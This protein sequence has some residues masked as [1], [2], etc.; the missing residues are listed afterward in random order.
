MGRS[1]W[2]LKIKRWLLA[3]ILS[4]WEGRERGVLAATEGRAAG[5]SE[6]VTGNGGNTVFAARRNPF[7]NAALM[8]SGALIGAL[9]L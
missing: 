6:W 8:L 1:R 2:L 4:G 3:A 5:N 9:A 7:W